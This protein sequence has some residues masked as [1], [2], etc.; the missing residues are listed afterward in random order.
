MTKV[1][2]KIENIYSLT[3]LQEGLLFHYLMESDSS[4]YVIQNV[5]NVYNV[6]DFEHIKQA[7]SLLT[8]KYQ[9]LRTMFV[10]EKVKAPCQVVLKERAAECEYVDLSGAE[11]SEEQCAE[12]IKSDVKRGFDLKNDTL[13]RVKYVKLSGSL[14]KLIFTTHHIIT[15]GWC[16]SILFSDFFSYYEMLCSGSSYNSILDKIV[17]KK[18]S[19]KDFG[20]Y[21]KWL[22]KQNTQKA[23]D[24]W[25]DLLEGYECDCQ[26]ASF[27]KKEMTDEKMRVLTKALSNDTTVRLKE[28]S[29]K[30][31]STINV[32]A[33]TA[34]GLLLQ[35]YNRS[36]DVVFG[37]VVSGRDADVSEI[38]NMVGLFINTIP[39]RIKTSET[40]TISEIIADVQKQGIESSRFDFCSLAD[41]QKRTILGSELIKILFVFENQNSGSQSIHIN[42]EY[43]DIEFDQY[44]EETSYAIS[45]V[46]FEENDSLQF[47]IMFDPNKYSDGDIQLVLDRLIKI[48]EEMANAPDC[49]VTEIDSVTDSERKLILNDFNATAMDY[50]RDKT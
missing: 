2:S 14:Y 38:E 22:E 48:C 1:N 27:G 6:L 15:D 7:L 36:D 31:E 42:D 30:A 10:Y 47:K 18:K 4:A 26:I 44:R 35:K 28:I 16:N 8:T 24:Y 50:P 39:V 32:V 33:E 49:K 46:G 11:D 45:I 43:A 23:K 5:F 12:L 40:T 17:E 34:V 9:A 3:P 21:I 19:T 37:K 25:E 20:D 41:I 13:L 29:E